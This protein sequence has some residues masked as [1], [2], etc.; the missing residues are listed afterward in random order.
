M[1]QATDVI[2]EWDIHAD[3]L[4]TPNW[5]KKFGYLLHHRRHQPPHSL[6]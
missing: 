1:D 5:L 3:T 4:S 2:F 6:F